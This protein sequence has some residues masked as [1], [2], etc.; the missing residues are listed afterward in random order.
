M[1][2]TTTPASPPSWADVL[3]LVSQLDES[4]LE[5][6][7]IITAGVQVRVSR[8]SLSPV[9]APAVAAPPAQ[10]VH[11]PVAPRIAEPPAPVVAAP[12]STGPEI[13]APML[14][15][16]Y[17]RPAPDE[18]PFVKVGDT[19]TADTTVAILEVM[20]MMNSVAAGVDG[21]IAEVCV[22][23]GQMVEYGEVLF[24]LESTT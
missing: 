19:V 16:V 4:G 22:D 6:A 1:A 21:V 10:P 13:K 14:G 12:A 2:D 23:E 9:L 20:K 11:E 3:A 17:H 7:E 5:D 18:E 8:S 24:R 15:V